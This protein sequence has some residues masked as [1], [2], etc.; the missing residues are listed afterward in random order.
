MMGFFNISL[1]IDLF[2]PQ[3]LCF[4]LLSSAFLCFSY[5]FLCFLILLQLNIWEKVIDTILFFN[6]LIVAHSKLLVRARCCFCFNISLG[7]AFYT[8]IPQFFSALTDILRNVRWNC[9]MVLLLWFVFH[10]RWNCT[11]GFI[12]LV[13]RPCQCQTFLA[14]TR[15]YGLIIEASGTKGL[16]IFLWLHF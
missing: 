15:L 7:S 16:H 11:H 10:V 13:P 4:P 12:T 6:Y 14:N 3:F 8:A 5:A 9:I 1:A 2:I